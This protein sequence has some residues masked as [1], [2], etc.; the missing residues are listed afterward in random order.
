MVRLAFD[1]YS[2]DLISSY[3]FICQIPVLHLLTDINS[4][5]EETASPTIL[6]VILSV[7][8]KKPTLPLESNM[9]PSIVEQ[10]NALISH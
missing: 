6:S 3:S 9:H 8:V 5:W 1:L 2:I 4:P 10:D 7:D